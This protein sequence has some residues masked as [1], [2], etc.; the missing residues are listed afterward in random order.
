MEPF[1]ITDGGSTNLTNQPAGTYTIGPFPSGS[2]SIVV[3]SET[4]SNCTETITGNLDC[5]NCDLSG[6]VVAECID[7]DTY[8]VELTFTGTGTYT[9]DGGLGNV[10]TGQSAG[11]FV[12]GPYSNGAYSIEV[13]SELDAT[14]TQTFA[15][16]N[17][18]FECGLLT[19]NIT[20]DCIDL[21]SYEVT[22]DL[23]GNGT[24]AILYNGET[25]TGQTAGTFTVGPFAEGTY[26]IQISSEQDLTCTETLTGE[27][28]CFECDLVV[29]S[30]GTDCVEDTDDFEVSFTIGGTGTFTISD[31]VNV[32]LTGQIAGDYTLGSYPEGAYSIT[33]TSETDETCTETITGT[34]DCF[35]C[36]L[37]VLTA[38]ALCND[39]ATFNVL[40]NFTGEGLYT[41]TNNSNITLINQPAGIYN[42]GPFPNG[43]YSISIFNEEDPT[44]QEVVSGVNE[45]F[46]CEL[47]NF[48]TANCIDEDGFEV[49]VTLEGDDSYTIVYNGNGIMS[50]QTAGNVS[51][52]LFDNGVYNLSIT[53]ETD[54]NCTQTYT[55]TLD[56]TPDIVCDPS[57]VAIPECIDENSYNLNLTLGGTG[58][59]TVEYNDILLEGKQQEI[60][61]LGLS[62]MVL[63]IY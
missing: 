40:L 52:G 22:F 46:E 56:C 28:T 13:T 49:I 55:G 44:C 37:S 17:D 42:L 51:V 29:S 32:D 27:H 21:E 35:V 15:G 33:I 54:E 7:N 11:I 45:C 47:P 58:T 48:V 62:A 36:D 16:S 57:A 3:T 10:L 39:L 30:V 18:C 8:N 1:T 63:T 9:I 41:I 19:S 60:L 50:G 43:A 24:Y 14:C 34:R 26:S 4:D 25:L 5:F 6:S 61:R 23:A 38:E 31:G 20:T 59:F 2:Y 12:F 53:S